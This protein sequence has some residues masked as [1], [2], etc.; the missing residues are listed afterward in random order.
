VIDGEGKIHGTVRFAMTGEEALHWRQLALGND[1]DEVK[2][3]F[4]E[5]VRGYVPAGIEADFDHFLG[6]EDVKSALIG[7]VKVNGELGTATGKRFFVPGMFFESNAAHPFAALEKRETPIDVEYPRTAVDDVTYKLPA[8]YALEGAAPAADVN[9][10]GFAAMQIVPETRGDLVSVK[11]TLQYDF[12]LLAPQ[13][14]P[15]LHGFYQKVATADQQQL[16]LTRTATGSS[17]GKGN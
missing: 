11:R 5:W 16:V 6:M 8:G 3:Q 15:E 10:P 9:W 14:Y 4:S 12:V 13:K 17:A 7:I 1:E 2:R